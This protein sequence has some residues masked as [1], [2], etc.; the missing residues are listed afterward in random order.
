ML[1]FFYYNQRTFRCVFFVGLEL[2]AVVAVVYIRPA[3]F[4]CV[5]L[6]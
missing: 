2:I 1:L 4:L 3:S 5:R 6:S